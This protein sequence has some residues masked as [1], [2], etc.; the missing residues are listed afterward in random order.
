VA[1]IRTYILHHPDTESTQCWNVERGWVDSAT[2][3]TEFSEEE[4]QSAAQWGH[5]ND[6]DSHGLAVP[7]GYWEAFVTQVF[8]VTAHY[9]LNGVRY[10]ETVVVNP[11]ACSGEAKVVLLP[12]GD[13]Y[14]VEAYGDDHIETLI[15]E[16]DAAADQLVIPPERYCE[17]Q[18][19]EEN[20]PGWESA[21]LMGNASE[22][23]DLDGVFVYEVPDLIY[24]GKPGDLY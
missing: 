1:E 14:V 9:T 15:D 24:V 23:V 2:D 4:R 6:M 21:T 12:S 22:P 17:Y 20:S 3:A 7:P 11:G 19:E 16:C 10:T 13:H 5:V 18:L 8:P